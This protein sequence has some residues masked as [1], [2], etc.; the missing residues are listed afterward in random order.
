VSNFLNSQPTSENYWRG[1]VLLGRNVATYKLALAKSIL[2]LS[3]AGK[4]FVTLEDLAVPYTRHL[5]E[6]LRKSEKQITSTSSKFLDACRKFN[7]GQ[8]NQTALVDAA[9]NLEASTT[10][11]TPS[12]L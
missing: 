6:H 10:S 5:T 12:M 1:I 3:S 9:V 4:T 7:Q 8:L 2:E 11:S